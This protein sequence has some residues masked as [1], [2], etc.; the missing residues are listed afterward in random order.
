LFPP[1]KGYNEHLFLL[2]QVVNVAVAARGPH[3]VLALSSSSSSRDF[4]LDPEFDKLSPSS[5]CYLLARDYLM[6]LMCV[7]V[8]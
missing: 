5:V 8:W 2:M 6:D 7:C 1:I 3:C 4:L